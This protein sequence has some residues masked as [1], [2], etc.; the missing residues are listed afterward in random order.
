[1]NLKKVLEKLVK[2]VT[3]EKIISQKDVLE[4]AELDSEEYFEIE[5]ALLNLNVDIIEEKEEKEFED[6]D[7]SLIHI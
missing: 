3:K 4:F 5:K 6:K 7:L 2:K 1:M